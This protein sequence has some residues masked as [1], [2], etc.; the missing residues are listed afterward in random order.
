MGWAKNFG[1]PEGFIGKVMLTGMNHD[2]AP[3]YRWGLSHF[4]WKDNT[5]ALDVGCGGGI[6]IRRMLSFSESCKVCG[7]DISD[8]AVMK[9]MM[10][11]RDLI[12]KRCLVRKGAAEA[13]PF[14]DG[15]FDVVTAFETVYFW[16]D[17]PAA[18]SEIYR[19]LKP[20]GMLI[21]GCKKTGT[22]TICTKPRSGKVIYTTDALYEM[23]S[24]A[25]YTDIT[26]ETNDRSW[27]CIT[28]R[29]P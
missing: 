11:N 18:F 25:G 5:T 20:G 22:G 21:V 7:I 1:K 10:M 14:K 12:G 28:G 4:E 29:K 27:L 15:V 6:N 13:V 17:V 16:N 8:Q 2:H 24:A 19:V 26:A 3:F 9:S 23:L